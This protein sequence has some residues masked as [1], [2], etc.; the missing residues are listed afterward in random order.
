MESPCEKIL[1]VDD[2]PGVLSALQA[3]LS[4]HFN[5]TAVMSAE[6]ALANLQ[7]KDFAAIISD[8]RMPGVDGLRLLKQCAV[9]YPNMVRIILTAFD[10]D[11]VLE[12]ALG[13]HG[14]FKLVKPW[15]DDLLITLKNALA[16]RESAMTLRRHLD[17]KSELL[18]IDRRLH[19]ELNLDE[20]LTQAAQ[21]MLRS[22]QVTA[23][24]IYL[25][26]ER[27][28]PEEPKVV[29]E[30]EEGC[31]PEL[32]KTRSCPVR[33]N[34][35]FLYT[36]PIGRWSRPWAAI[37]VELSKTDH[38]T[39]RYLDF[40]GRQAYKTLRL[41][42]AGATGDSGSTPLPSYIADPV[43]P[44]VTVNWIVRQLTTPTT[45]LST[46]VPSMRE[47]ADDLTCDDAAEH[48]AET[49]SE[50]RELAADLQTVSEQFLQILEHLRELN[51]TK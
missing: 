8:V 2:D 21:E 31:V 33:Y 29:Q 14:A 13:P 17:L 6:Q 42:R 46:A 35:R 24:A 30:N 27:G 32:H 7:T 44:Q 23:A 25:F 16:Q 38:E 49:A 11:E 3:E 5:V 39:T 47:L 45:V 50:I 22:P 34:T 36:V 26:D 1:I 43:A 40:V 18:D 4:D 10:G 37:A 12:T 28:D 19:T 41:I 9:R 48:R 51:A 20:L 15:G